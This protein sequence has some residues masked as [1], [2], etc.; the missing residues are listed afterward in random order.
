MD[1]S[2]KTILITGGTGSFG[3]KFAALLLEK[4]RPKKLIVF[5]RDEQKQYCMREGGFN[6]S[7]IRYFI[8]DVR[9]KDRLYRAFYGVDIVVHAAAMKQ[10]P[11]SEYNPF[12]AI[13][14][15]VIGAANVIDAA[16]DCGVERVIALSTDKAT[17]PI[18]LYGATKL[19]ADK[20]FIAGNAYSGARKTRICVARYGNVVGSRGSVIPYFGERR[21]TGVIPVTDERMT[22]FWI[23]LEHGA[24]FV[25]HCLEQMHGGEVFVPKIPSMK[26]YDLARVIAPHC[27]IEITGIRPGEKL[28]EVMI[29][30]DDARHTVE[31]PDFYVIQ[32]DFPW[33]DKMNWKAGLPCA[34][35]FQYSSDANSHWLTHEEM[36]EMIA[37]LGLLGHESRHEER[38]FLRGT[39]GRRMVPALPQS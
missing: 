19:C 22:R 12:E 11:T 23:T 26:I 16:I 17:N 37:N 15:N 35:G 8:G 30:S 38:N 13:K 34:E 2:E 20:L 7:N 5:S 21:K 36:E 27:R 18:N 24:R 28:H 25:V 9:D 10:V 29:S 33:W 31:L 6:S 1:W 39:G 4:Y 32:P 3:Q 14:T